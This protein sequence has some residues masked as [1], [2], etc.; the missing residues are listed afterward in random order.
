MQEWLEIYNF[1]TIKIN[2]IIFFSIRIIFFN[3][4]TTA[5]YSWDIRQTWHLVGSETISGRS[6]V[7]VI[8]FLLKLD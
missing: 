7:D 1:E 5:L 4:G 3:L 2:I 6:S 8:V